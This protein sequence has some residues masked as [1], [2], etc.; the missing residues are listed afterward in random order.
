ME[1]ISVILIGVSYICAIAALVLF[2]FGK[3]DD[4]D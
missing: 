2:F 1:T 4:L 3:D